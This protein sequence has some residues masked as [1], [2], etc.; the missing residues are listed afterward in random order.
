MD[1]NMKQALEQFL[2]ALRDSEAVKNYQA[3]KDR[4]IADG[5]LIT[6]VNEYNMQGQ[7]LRDEGAK[8]ERDDVLIGQITEKLKETYDAIMRNENMVAFQQAEQAVS[9][10]I[11]DVDRGIRSVVMPEDV[12][13]GACS[14]NCSTCGGCH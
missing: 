11:S 2:N 13:G 9:E 5:E 8:P 6:L 4:Y 1:N 10:L 14:G 3:A 12:E 7:M